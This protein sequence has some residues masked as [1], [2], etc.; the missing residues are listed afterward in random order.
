MIRVRRA[1]FA[2]VPAMLAISNHYALTTPANFAVEPESLESW[3]VTFNATHEMYP[4]LVAVDDESRSNEILG[5]AKA[6]PWK[7][8]CAYEFAA[9]TTV[10]IRSE[11]HRRGVGR[12]LYTKLLATMKAQ[13]YMCALGGIALPND[14]SVALHEACGFTHVGTLRRVGWKF[15]RWH[16][17]G[18]WQALLANDPDPP[19]RPLRSVHAAM[20][21]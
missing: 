21:D 1:T 6:S 9:E 17:V 5:F 12:A 2:D 7:G 18:Y 3:Q 11:H 15:D 10:Y 13:G 16:D 8:R 4:W 14:A 19:P 20:S